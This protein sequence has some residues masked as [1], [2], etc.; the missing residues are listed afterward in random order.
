M[1]TSIFHYRLRRLCSLIIGLVFLLAGVFK[2]LDPVGAGLVV[3]EYYHFLHLEFLLPSAK[4][5][6]VTLALIEALLGAALI[7][8]VWRKPVAIATTVLTVLFTIL[9]L[10][11]AI[12]NPS[13][14]CGCFGEV[15]HLS[16][17]Q[18]FIKNV[19][20]LILALIAFAPYRELGEA[21]K[22]KHVAFFIAAASLA[23]FTI[24]SL[25]SLPLVDFTPFVPGSELLAADDDGED[26]VSTFIYEKNGQERAFTLDKLPDSTWTFIRTETIRM[27]GPKSGQGTPVLSF[28]DSTGNYK[29]ELAAVGNALVVSVNAP[30]KLK[31]DDWTRVSKVMEGASK[32]GFTPLLLVS[33]TKARMERISTMVP[34]VRDILLPGIYFS[35]RKTLLAMNRSNGGATWFNDGQL[36][37]KFHSGKLPSDEDLLRMTG[38]DPAETMLKTS[39]KG[40]LRFQGF[41]L[42]TIALLL[43]I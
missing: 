35:D 39:V 31:G 19:V 15:I 28:T 34:E 24:Y 42:Y 21:K 23:A 5:V 25:T 16:N 8:G 38:E 12:V 36:I 13:M 43:L 29:D 3:E 26:F 40:R 20:L 10:I 30:A 2:L 33:G 27:N 17:L 9:T 6:A 11:L 41:L 18:T 1:N 37:M 7:A 4:V 22:R 14:D 32:A